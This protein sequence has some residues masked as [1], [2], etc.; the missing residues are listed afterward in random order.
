MQGEKHLARKENK[1]LMSEGFGVLKWT[2]P[3]CYVKYLESVNMF[4][5]VSGEQS[6][7]KICVLSHKM[8]ILHI[9]GF[10]VVA[11]QADKR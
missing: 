4:I 6:P 10:K 7:D 1:S 2:C 11:T 3:L 5:G 8:R 9:C